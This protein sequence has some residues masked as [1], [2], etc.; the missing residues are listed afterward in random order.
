MCPT[1]NDGKDGGREKAST[2]D[3]EKSLKEKENKKQ[4]ESMASFH[5]LFSFFPTMGTKI[6]F[7]IGILA[8]ICNGLIYPVLAYSFSKTF[9]DLGGTAIDMA[10]IR[11]IAFTFV[12][13]G[14]AAFAAGTVQSWCLE[15]AAERATR[16]FRQSWFKALLRQD[17]AYFDVYEVGG[18]ASTIG[19]NTSKVRRGLGVKLGEGIQFAT[20][21]IGGLVYS[22]YSNWKVTLVVLGVLPF[23]AYI[24]YAVMKLNQ[25]KSSRAAESYKAAGGVVYSTVSSIRTVLS[26]NAAPQMVRQYTDATQAAHDSGVS[27]LINEGIVKYVVIVFFRINYFC[28]IS[29]ANLYLVLLYV[30]YTV[31]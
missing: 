23:V 31:D 27:T 17:A 15:I 8:A 21:A 11:Q 26:L 10:K 2:N 30:S 14:A 3:D 29:S 28:T 5:Q 24:G 25:T 20:T 9:S 7:T 19:A 13:L 1:E 16:N 4:V 6:I 22:L 18:V 12:G